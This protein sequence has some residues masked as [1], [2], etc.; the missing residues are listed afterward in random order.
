MRRLLLALTFVFLAPVAQAQIINYSVQCDTFASASLETL[1]ILSGQPE[2]IHD[3]DEGTHLAFLGERV[4]GAFW[5]GEAQVDL[6]RV[7]PDMT[8]I[9][10]V[11]AMSGTG[12][13]SWE[14]AVRVGAVWQIVLGGSGNFP[15]TTDGYD[16]L[17]SDVSAV[18]VR[19]RGGNGI[20]SPS[21]YHLFE[22]RVLGPHS[23]FLCADQLQ[24][25]FGLKSCG[26]DHETCSGL[27]NSSMDPVTLFTFLPGGGDVTEHGTVRI[28]QGRVDV[29]GL[30]F[31]EIHGLLAFELLDSE[32]GIP[33][34]SRLI[35]INT[36]SAGG[37]PIGPVL[38]GR[39]IRGAAFDQLGQLWAVD[40]TN[41][42][43]L[44]IHPGVGVQI[45]S[46]V[47]LT[48]NGAP[49]NLSE[50]TDI[51]FRRDGLLLLTHAS[52]SMFA[53]NP[54]T[55]VMALVFQDGEADDETASLPTHAGLAIPPLAP[56]HAYA[57]DVRQRED[58]FRY[59]FDLGGL[60]T[61]LHSEIVPNYNAGMG[62]LASRTPPCALPP[63][64][65]NG[66]EVEVANNGQS[67]QLRWTENPGAAGYVVFRD[68]ESAGPFFHTHGSTI[69][70]A[71]GLTF[72]MPE[73]DSYF[74]V[75]EDG[76]CAIGPKR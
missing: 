10:V 66:L 64:A 52:A 15:T 44:Q 34:G 5:G 48:R 45:G 13:G 14:I 12:G 67:L 19:V 53:V 76:S 75:A 62:D 2:T 4:I 7:V 39:N 54:L 73:G 47:P 26:L 46:A 35:E 71:G 31:S 61:E 70:G 60:R 20:I 17:V 68:D 69:S 6:G 63:G 72:Q 40:A 32:F 11:H 9:E 42:E 25:F 36:V 23:S 56:F 21:N 43:L 58:L 22:L 3:D 51:A 37:T 65:V 28:N 59:Q 8:R 33:T 38:A 57:Y 41:N 18:R 74:L 50:A 16:V 24:G 49:F 29:D 1:G 55:G 30:A 27:G